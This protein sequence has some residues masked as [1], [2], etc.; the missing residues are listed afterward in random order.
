MATK[1]TKTV[2]VVAKNVVPSNNGVS[3]ITRTIA[4][5]IESSAEGR[6]EISAAW[7][8]SR[9]MFEANKITAVERRRAAARARLVANARLAGI[10]V[11]FEE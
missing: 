2:V 7:T 10:E 3:F 4:N 5:A 1:P 8:I 6:A 9:E 11:Q